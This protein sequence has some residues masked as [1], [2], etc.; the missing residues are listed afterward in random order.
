MDNHSGTGM[1]QSASHSVDIAREGDE[2]LC[3]THAFS[4]KLYFLIGKTPVPMDGFGMIISI[5][6][7]QADLGHSW[8]HNAV[9]GSRVCPFKSHVN[10]RGLLHIIGSVFGS[11][12]SSSVEER[13]PDMIARVFT[14]KINILPFSG[15][16]HFSPDPWSTLR[17]REIY[18][19]TGLGEPLVYYTTYRHV[20]THI[21]AYR[22]NGL[23]L[24][25]GIAVY[26]ALSLQD[27][28]ELELE[29]LHPVL[30]TV[31]PSHNRM[32]KMHASVGSC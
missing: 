21:S 24:G 25:S 26:T 28:V 9:F 17:S 6:S 10:S 32:L 31:T 15:S 20:V 1:H 11:I 18:W 5:R 29:T 12:A 19:S 4:H 13:R 16:R 7:L 27:Y 8:Y 23:G 30:R 3:C 14:S 22:D 2:R